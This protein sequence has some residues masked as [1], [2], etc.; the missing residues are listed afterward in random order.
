LGDDLEGDLGWLADV[1]RDQVTS[2]A[3]Y[4][5]HH[6]L[7]SMAHSPSL[8]NL[9]LH[10]SKS[11]ALLENPLVVSG[12]R[13]NVIHVRNLFTGEAVGQRMVGHGDA[14]TAVAVYSGGH[15]RIDGRG[16]Q[17][18]PLAPFVVS[19]SE[20]NDIRIW[21]LESRA[22]L[23]VIQD[24]DFDVTS[25]A[26][27]AP[28]SS[29]LPSDEE[30]T[31][32]DTDIDTDTDT[33]GMKHDISSPSASA[34]GKDK[35]KARE[36]ILSD[37]DSTEAFTSIDS[38]SKLPP[39]MHTFSDIHSHSHSHTPVA[40][41]KRRKVEGGRRMNQYSPYSNGSQQQQ[42][43]CLSRGRLSVSPHHHHD[44]QVRPLYITH[45]C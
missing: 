24:H 1:H 15:F 8:N 23:A 6:C 43:Q 11:F 44:D 10:T 12:G 41:K 18:E 3:L 22:C 19:A 29:S 20:D 37:M 34:S 38:K 27:Y 17:S 7:A 40:R 2:L 30:G 39:L 16:G 42:S 33:A 26:I 35:G 31:C 21:S 28:L 32:I 4:Y 45:T 36:H 9:P 5:P 25:L 14:I 13:D